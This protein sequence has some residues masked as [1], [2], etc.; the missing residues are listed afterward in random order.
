MLAYSTNAL[1]MVH[2]RKHGTPPHLQQE[3]SRKEE[4]GRHHTGSVLPDQ[5]NGSIAG[6]RGGTAA[7]SGGGRGSRLGLV[8]GRALRSGGNSGRGSGR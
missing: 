6:L 5:A 7:S 3:T 4:H 8:S 1:G 2:G